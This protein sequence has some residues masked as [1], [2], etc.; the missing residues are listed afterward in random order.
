[1]KQFNTLLALLLFACLRG[2]A[3]DVNAPP[4]YFFSCV[5]CLTNAPGDFAMKLS[6][7]I[8][9][10][11]QWQDVFSIGLDL[12]KTNCAPTAG[13]DTT[14]YLEFRPNL[15]IFQVGKFVNTFTPGLGYVFGASQNMMLEFTQGIEYS[16][17]PLVHLN[18]FYGQYY[19][20]G[21]YANS[22]VSFFGVS[23]AKFL[24]PSKARGIIPT[25]QKAL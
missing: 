16:F 10:G 7:T 17:T 6:P 1:M 19:Y 8:E 12:G 20:S 2:A 21:K 25:K 24:K 23:I 22:S 5:P 9:V 18:I 13:K 3:Q 4:Q 11:R 14:V 15:N